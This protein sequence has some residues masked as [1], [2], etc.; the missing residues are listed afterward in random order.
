MPTFQYQITVGSTTL[1]PTSEAALVSLIAEADLAVPVNSCRL[2]LANPPTLT[3]GDAV[4]VKLGYDSAPQSV[5]KG[6]IAH[7]HWVLDGLEVEAVSQLRRLTTT[8]LNLLFEKSTAKAI[9][10]DVA[11]R[12]RVSMGKAEAGIQFPAYALGDQTSAYGHLHHL[13]EQCGFDIYG[14]CADKLVFAPYKPSQ[15]HDFSY[16]VNILAYSWSERPS[17]LTGVEVYGESP[18]SQGQGDQAYSWLSKKEVK[19]SSGKRS[20]TTLH[21]VEPTARTQAIA[22][23]IATA[24]LKA[25]QVQR[26]GWVK[27]LGNPAVGLGDRLSL[28]KLPIAA[29]SGRYKITGVR[30]C[31]SQRR[32]F[33]TTLQWQEEP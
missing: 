32:G 23:N 24:L 28:A 27:G 5:F 20:G 4:E 17:P 1:T 33:C 29:H 3:V 18:A 6:E 31:L 19:G 14:D 10:T 25:H 11:K 22:G 12:C 21:R 7:L 15:T 26:Q 30:H 13:A 16:G 2:V 9:A 8:Y